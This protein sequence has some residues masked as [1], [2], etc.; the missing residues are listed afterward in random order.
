MVEILPLNAHHYWLLRLKP[1]VKTQLFFY[2]V[3]MHYLRD[4]QLIWSLLEG[5]L[6]KVDGRFPHWVTPYT[7]ERYSLIYVS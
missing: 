7:G 1:K 6:A 2:L 5:R 4:L 3:L